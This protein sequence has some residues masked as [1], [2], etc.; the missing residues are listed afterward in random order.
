ML[1]KANFSSLKIRAIVAFLS[2]TKIS[3]GNK[4]ETASDVVS[5]V[6]SVIAIPKEVFPFVLESTLISTTAGDTALISK[7]VKLE[8]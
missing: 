1:S 4:L 2:F 7:S 6:D 8:A 3:A 5:I